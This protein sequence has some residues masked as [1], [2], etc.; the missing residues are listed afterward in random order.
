[1]STHSIEDPRPLPARP[2]LRHLKDQARDLL[3]AGE[4]ESL[5]SA[6]LQIA[7]RYGFAS[8]PKLKYHVEAFQRSERA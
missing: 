8:W 4:V 2:N 5:T 6:Q 1:M 3:R 7:R